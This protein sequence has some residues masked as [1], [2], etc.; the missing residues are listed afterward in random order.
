MSETKNTIPQVV[1]SNA[2]NP[3]PAGDEARILGASMNHSMGKS[4]LADR[5]LQDN[6]REAVEQEISRLQI[7][8]RPSTSV[9]TAVNTPGEGATS[10][11]PVKKRTKPSQGERQKLKRKNLAK[12]AA[13]QG[14]NGTPKGEQKSPSTPKNAKRGR[15][16]ATSSSSTG[17]SGKPRIQPRKKLAT[18]KGPGPAAARKGGEGTSSGPSQPE[19]RTHGAGGRNSYGQVA[20][21]ASAVVFQCTTSPEGYTPEQSNLISVRLEKAIAAAQREGIP[22]KVEDPGGHRRMLRVTAVDNLTKEWLQNY[23]DSGKL[24]NIWD[25]AK[26]KLT[27][28]EALEKVFKASLLVPCSTHQDTANILAQIKGTNPSLK[29][30]DWS[31]HSNL[32]VERPTKGN[33]MHLSIPQKD[34]DILDRQK[35]V[36]HL[37]LHRV[38]IHFGIPKRKNTSKPRPPNAKRSK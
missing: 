37:G 7:A 15:P 34:K 22:L 28:V 11:K 23:V 29:T 2:A 19:R 27:S 13:E 16:I 21:R 17:D 4:G 10:G 30:E 38:D 6:R 35:G 18:G 1:D 32:Y 8:S 3:P 5:E 36:L 14:K 26:F 9:D 12:Q 33:L 24:E 20:S 31:V 25:G